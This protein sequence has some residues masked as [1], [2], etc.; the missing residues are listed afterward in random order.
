MQWKDSPYLAETY[1]SKIAEN[2]DSEIEVFQTIDDAVK[3]KQG[4]LIDD[5]LYVVKSEDVSI[6]KN[7]VNQ[8]DGIIVICK[9]WDGSSDNVVYMPEIMDWQI[10]E[11]IKAKCPGL[12]NQVIKWIQKITSNNIYR[13]NNEIEKISLFKPEE[14]SK[15]FMMM[16]NDDCFCDLSLYNGFDVSNAILKKDFTS[17]KDIYD[18]FDSAELGA[19]GLL[20]ILIR[21]FKLLIQMQI[22]GFNMEQLGIN[23]GQFFAIK[24]QMNYYSNKQLLNAYS[25]L[26]GIDEKIKN[27]KLP[28][29]EEQLINYIIFNVLMEGSK[30]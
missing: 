1:A 3:S 19:Q 22:S 25:F 11:L 13:I 30:K 8:L 21:N 17:L 5:I 16:N 12:D 27:G 26:L 28:L 18:E 15:L 10:A 6:G 14:Q 7:D 20:T 4:N 23:K 29:S 24:N 9:Y 2:L